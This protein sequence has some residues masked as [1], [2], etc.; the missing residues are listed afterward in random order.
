MTGCDAARAAC[1]KLRA[2]GESSPSD[3]AG[4]IRS[5]RK[6]ALSSSGI[7][8]MPRSVEAADTRVVKPTQSPLRTAV[9]HAI[10]PAGRYASSGSKPASRQSSRTAPL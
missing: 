9:S 6:S 5:I 4:M 1:A 3:A 8:R 10:G 7:V 2:G